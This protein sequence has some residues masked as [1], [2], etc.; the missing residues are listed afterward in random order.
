VEET[1]AGSGLGEEKLI[2]HKIHIFKVI[3]LAKADYH[4]H[5]D[6]VRR[7]V[8]ELVGANKIRVP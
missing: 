4:Y 5:H 2:V 3:D 8:V 1:H 7:R 6:Y